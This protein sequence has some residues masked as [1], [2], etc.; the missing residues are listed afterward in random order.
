M[1]RNSKSAAGSRD[2]R[3]LVRIVLGDPVLHANVLRVLLLLGAVI[4]GSGILRSH[5]ATAV[6]CELEAQ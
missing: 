2:P 3:L 4:V 6:A 5:S 1:P